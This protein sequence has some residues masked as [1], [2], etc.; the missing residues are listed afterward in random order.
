MGDLLAG[1]LETFGEFE[2]GC[3]CLLGEGFKLGDE[4]EV[5]ALCYGSFTDNLFWVEELPGFA[6]C[7]S[8]ADCFWEK[9]FVV[10]VVRFVERIQEQEIG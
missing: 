4:R 3:S 9:G 7:G 2:E 1:C 10:G 8:I 6:R 5:V